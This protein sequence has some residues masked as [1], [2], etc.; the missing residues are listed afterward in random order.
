MWFVKS[1]KAIKCLNLRSMRTLIK[2]DSKAV[3]VIEALSKKLFTHM[4]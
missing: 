4:S 2:V 1:I 3:D